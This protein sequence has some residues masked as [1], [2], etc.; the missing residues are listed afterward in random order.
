MPRH[1]TT[2]NGAASK[3][4]HEICISPSES[5]V[6]IMESNMA[7]AIHANK[8]TLK[9]SG[10]NQCL[11]DVLIHVSKLSETSGALSY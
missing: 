6:L 9:P 4:Q 3:C 8:L 11:K 10:L 7:S 2:E 1:N 5:Q